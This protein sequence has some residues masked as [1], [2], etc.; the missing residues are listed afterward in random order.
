MFK[1]IDSA[2]IWLFGGAFKRFPQTHQLKE[3]F[4]L[5]HNFQVKAPRAWA[6]TDPLSI[7]VGTLAILSACSAGAKSLRS[8]YVSPQ[9]YARLEMELD[10]L[11]DVIKFVDGLVTEHQLTGNA[12]IKNLT[13]AR[14]KLQ[15]VHDFIFNSLRHSSLSPIKRWTLV[16]HKHRLVSFAKDIETAK[17]HIVDSIL[18][19]NL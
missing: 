7:T 9:E 8:A 15:E 14:S 13:I 16:R 18:L 11:H 17:G 1:A 10:H 6:M 4:A 19:S 12:L 2:K 3:A 5:I